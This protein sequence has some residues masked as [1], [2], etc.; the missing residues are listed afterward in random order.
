MTLTA[1]FA[2]AV[3]LSAAVSADSTE[4]DVG[5][6]VETREKTDISE[7]Y[8]RAELK[9]A[10]GYAYIYD[11]ADPYYPEEDVEYIYSSSDSDETFYTVVGDDYVGRRTIRLS[12]PVIPVKSGA[13][14]STQLYDYDDTVTF[15]ANV[16]GSGTLKISFAAK[17]DIVDVIVVD[18]SKRI[19]SPKSIEV[20]KG[21]D[22]SSYYSYVVGR[23]NSTEKMFASVSKYNVKKGTYYIHVRYGGAAGLD[24][25]GTGKMSLI[26]TYPTKGSASDGSIRYMAV[27]LDRNSSMTLGLALDE[28]L[29][30]TVTWSSSNKNVA[31]VSSSG[32]VIAKKKGQAVI[33]ATLA[34]GSKTNILVSVT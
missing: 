5:E 17:M 26:A 1:M 9:V 15:R 33:T 32:R 28:Y 27:K 7:Y 16:G 19:I 6:I 4:N 2:A 23:R 25:Y 11:E 20:K 13:Q 18:A 24:H 30:T 31:T 12:A 22:L 34:N 10:S 3:T 29:D 8:E 21:T 14:Y